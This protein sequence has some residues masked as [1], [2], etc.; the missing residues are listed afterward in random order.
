MKFWLYGA[1]FALSIAATAIADL[2]LWRW[3][4]VW[5]LCVYATKA[6]SAAQKASMPNKWHWRLRNPFYRVTE[7]SHPGPTPEG[8]STK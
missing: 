5:L 3:L 6:F 4:V 2:P 7:F 8:D 1:A